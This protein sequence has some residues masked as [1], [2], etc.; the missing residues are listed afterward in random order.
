MKTFFSS[1]FAGWSWTTLDLLNHLWQSTAVALALL[2]LLAFSGRLSA[3]T[4]RLLGWMA[5]LKFAFPIALLFR[6][7][8]MSGSAFDRWFGTRTFILPTEWS[9]SMA[10]ISATT[11]VPTRYDV[12]LILIGAWITVSVGLLGL[13]AIRGIRVRR[14]ILA[15]TAPVSAALERS[16]ADAASLVGISKLPRRLNAPADRSPGLLGVFSP[17]L[18][19]PSGIAET[20]SPAELESVLIHEFVHLRRRDNF[21]AAIQA[22]FG[23][24]FWFHPLVALLNRRISAETEKSCDEQ[25]L[26]ITRDPKN[27]A[28]GIVKCVR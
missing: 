22:I 2:L 27:Y 13:W 25:V 1:L 15:G 21:W 17:I 12:P 28:G 10:P 9:Q 20:L 19:L 14:A 11:A 26:A 16:I 24:L 6:V 7:I 3:N 8:A 23:A 5:L 18:I 4:R